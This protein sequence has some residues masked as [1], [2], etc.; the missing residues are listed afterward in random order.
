M[1]IKYDSSALGGGYSTQVEYHR[2][3]TGPN[4]FVVYYKQRSVVCFD[5]ISVKRVFG[6]AKF[7]PSITALGVWCDEMIEKYEPVQLPVQVDKDKGF[8]PECHAD[9]VEESS[10][11]RMVI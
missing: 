4:Y 10:P 6:P 9:E 7:T 5:R 3:K 8:G 2:T 1:I 11:T